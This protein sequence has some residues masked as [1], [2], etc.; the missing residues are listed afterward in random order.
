MLQPGVTVKD[1]QAPRRLLR[2]HLF[3]VSL[4]LFWILFVWN[5]FAGFEATHQL[6]L[7]LAVVNESITVGAFLLRKG[8]EAVSRAPLDWALGF[9][10]TLLP[11][12]LRPAYPMDLSLGTALVSGGFLLHIGALLSLRRSFGIIVA[13]REI[14][15][16]G[17]YR[18][19]RHPI[20][21]SG[22]LVYLGYAIANTSWENAAI[23]V[24]VSLIFFARAMREEEFLSSSDE[25]GRYSRSTR[26]RFIP[27]VY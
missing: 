19:V 13:K 12:L 25:Y 14:R 11:T 16:G 4:A 20:Y 9:S 8:P 22:A 5:N 3:D 23:V 26:Y 2:R 15:S 6:G 18:I 10:G 17:L 1:T 24:S 7:A 27:F 21:A